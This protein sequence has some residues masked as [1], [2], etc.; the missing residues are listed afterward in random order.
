MD[1][2]GENT[3]CITGLEMR[4]LVGGGSRSIKWKGI[5]GTGERTIHMVKMCTGWVGKR[6]TPGKC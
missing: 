5:R 1:L 3:D 4:V 6:K 2:T